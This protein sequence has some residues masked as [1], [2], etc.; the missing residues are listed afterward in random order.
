MISIH[1]ID[2]LSKQNIEEHKINLKGKIYLANEGKPLPPIFHLLGNMSG[3]PNSVAASHDLPDVMTAD[4][5][6]ITQS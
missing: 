6:A 2:E 5:I 3:I 4:K 1:G